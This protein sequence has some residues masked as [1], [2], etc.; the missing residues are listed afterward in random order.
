MPKWHVQTLHDSKLNAPLP[1]HT[2]YGSQ[3]ASNALGCY[4][5]VVS[6][7][8]DEEEPVKF[9]EAQSSKRWMASMQAEYDAIV[10]NG[11]WSICD[12][13]AGKKAIGT[14]WAYKLK[15]KPDGSVDRHKAR[16]VAKVYAQE[17]GIEFEETF[18]PTCRMTTIH[19][20]CALAAH[21]GWNVH[22]LDI[23]TTFLNGDLHDLGCSEYKAADLGVREDAATTIY[24]DS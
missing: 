18:A 21:H 19:S 6:S 10:K 24:T 23:K 5:L 8:C 20:M 12:L 4:A 17:K 1:S 2:C 15:H 14:K 7:M 22:Q 13:P 9:N 3:H 11:T 16:H